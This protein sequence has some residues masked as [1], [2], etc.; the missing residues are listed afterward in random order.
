[1][2]RAEQQL[3]RVKVDT[4]RCHSHFLPKTQWMRARARPPFPLPFPLVYFQPKATLEI[5]KKNK[6]KEGKKWR[7]SFPMRRKNGNKTAQRLCPR[8]RLVSVFTRCLYSHPLVFCAAAVGS[9]LKAS[10]CAIPAGAM[11]R[12]RGEKEKKSGAGSQRAAAAAA[13]RAGCVTVNKKPNKQHK[14]PPPKK[15]KIKNPTDKVIISQTIYSRRKKKCN[16]GDFS[17]HRILIG[18][19]LFVKLKLIEMSLN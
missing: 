10:R 8:R 17:F 7:F 14:P 15:I 4:I 11:L 13:V 12:R 16:S 5:K 6:K 18:K 2:R 19:T 3:T 9:D 1:M